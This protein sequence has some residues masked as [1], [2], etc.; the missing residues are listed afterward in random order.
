VPQ[1]RERLLFIGIREDVGMAP[2]APRFTHE[3]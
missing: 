2:G 3:T 1:F